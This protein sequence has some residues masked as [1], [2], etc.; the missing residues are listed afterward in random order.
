MWP[1][2]LYHDIKLARVLTNDGIHRWSVRLAGQIAVKVD[3]HTIGTQNGHA[4]S[5]VA[6]PNEMLN[7]S[8]PRSHALSTKAIHANGIVGRAAPAKGKPGVLKASQKRDPAEVQR[9]RQLADEQ[10]VRSNEP[11]HDCADAQHCTRQIH[12]SQ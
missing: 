5:R 8:G 1:E 12:L 9:E 11:C 3:I 10:N 4:G 2:A 6:G 7:N